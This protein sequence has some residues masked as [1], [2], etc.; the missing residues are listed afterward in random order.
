[1]Q[2]LQ[3]IHNEKVVE[4]LFVIGTE[5]FWMLQELRFL[6]KSR[7][8]KSNTILL[9]K[10]ELANDINVYLRNHVVSND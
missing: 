7:K 2:N 3:A 4:Y 5:M 10:S 1:M 8:L 9:S 6:K